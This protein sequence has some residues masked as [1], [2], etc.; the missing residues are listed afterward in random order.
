MIAGRMFQRSGPPFLSSRGRKGWM[1]L[2]ASGI[3]TY[4]EPT[5]D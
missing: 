2:T 4:R 5:V 1:S 3:K